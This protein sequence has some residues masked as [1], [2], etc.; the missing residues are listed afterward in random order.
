MRHLF[1]PHS[2]SNLFSLYPTPH[3]YLGVCFPPW[4]PYIITNYETLGHS[5]VTDLKIVIMSNYRH[6]WRRP[7]WRGGTPGRQL[8]EQEENVLNRP[9]FFDTQLLMERKPTSRELGYVLDGME[10]Q[11]PSPKKPFS[12]KYLRVHNKRYQPLAL[13][14]RRHKN[15][16]M[17]YGA[18]YPHGKELPRANTMEEA[19][20]TTCVFYPDQ[21]N[22][23]LKVCCPHILLPCFGQPAVFPIPFPSSCVHRNIFK[24]SNT[25]FDRLH[26]L[27][28]TPIM[29]SNARRKAF[30]TPTKATFCLTSWLH[31]PRCASR[32]SMRLAIWALPPYLRAASLEWRPSLE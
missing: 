21:P 27:L 9:P 19:G 16:L 7:A 23:L 4:H 28:L 24:R 18:V 22:L 14:P 8:T 11:G 5:P 26:S 10:E 1:D 30:L 12:D 32:S 15:R 20:K 25:D 17:S 29:P 6:G 13:R 3:S 2:L 31:T